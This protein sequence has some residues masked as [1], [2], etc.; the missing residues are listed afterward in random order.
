MKTRALPV[1]QFLAEWQSTDGVLFD[2]RSPSEYQKG[3]IPGARSLPLLND[4][5]RHEIGIIY[6]Q[7]GRQEAVLAGFE[8]VGPL[9]HQIIQNA[10]NLSLGKPVFIYCWRG[11][12]RSN[13][14]AWLLSMAGMQVTLLEH[15]YKSFRNHILREFEKPRNIM[16]LGGKT[17]SG[18][19]DLLPFIT[20]N[21]NGIIDLENLANHKGSA[22]GALGL[23]PQPSQEHFENLLGSELMAT[24]PQKTL[25]LENESRQIGNVNLPNSVYD[26]IRGSHMV[27]V[28]PGDEARKQRILADYGCFPIA[29]LAERTERIG[30]RLGNNHLKS[31]L[32]ALQRNDLTTWLDIILVYYD[33]A[34]NYGNELRDADKYTIV[35]TKGSTLEAAAKKVKSAA[36]QFRAEQN[37]D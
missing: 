29:E 22:F 23:P 32:E 17:G 25:W 6:K 7:K 11:G 30:K 10:T 24:S 21:E 1:D 8:R 5:H 19:T 35:D 3:H 15:G 31:A 26:W 16:V 34:Y 2:S 33:K 27:A 20:D 12:M 14:S 13:I 18:K 9:F 28:D 4:E 37:H 36:T